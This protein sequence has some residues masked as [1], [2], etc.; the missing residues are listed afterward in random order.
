MLTRLTHDLKT[1]GTTLH[2]M[3]RCLLLHH[4]F[5]RAYAMIAVQMFPLFESA[6]RRRVAPLHRNQLDDLGR[7]LYD[8][9]E[10]ESLTTSCLSIAIVTQT[11]LFSCGHEAELIIGVRKQDAKLLGH[12]WVQLVDGQVIDPNDLRRGMV[13]LQRFSMR[14]QVEQWVAT[15]MAPT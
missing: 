2:A 11:L 13:V 15:I 10:Q 14:A 4:G 7:Y 1:Y 9:D 5:D 3:V 8:L 6:S 12:A